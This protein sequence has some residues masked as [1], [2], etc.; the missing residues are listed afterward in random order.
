MKITDNNQ[1]DQYKKWIGR[2]R[3]LQ[4]QIGVFGEDDSFMVM[5][6]GVHEFG[7]TIKPK[8]KYLT[9]PMKPELAGISPSELNEDL[10]VPRGTRILAR[11]ADN[12]QGFEAL[13]ALVSEVT[14]PERSYIRSG[15]DENEKAIYEYARGMLKRVAMMEMTADDF[16]N[17]LGLYI[18]NKIRQRIKSMND[19][20]NAPATVAVKGDNNP[21][22]GNSGRLRQSVVYKVMTR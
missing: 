7:M 8:G 12:E 4:L 17:R 1:I 16:Y 2:L 3:E 21:L 11:E 18:Q 22:I 13:Y 6:A 15:F 5:I 10:F 14:I 9:I 20:P 19:P